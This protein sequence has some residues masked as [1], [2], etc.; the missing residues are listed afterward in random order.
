[1]TTTTRRTS[2]LAKASGRIHLQIAGMTCSS[3]VDRVRSALAGVPGTRVIDVKPGSAAV[4]LQPEADGL[5]L[6]KAIAAAGYEVIGVHPLD[7][8]QRF[9][10]RTH[11]VSGGGCCCGPESAHQDVLPGPVRR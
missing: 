11:T 5:A 6:V 9:A 3:C 10:N 2:G 8:P 1:M 4:E 7:A